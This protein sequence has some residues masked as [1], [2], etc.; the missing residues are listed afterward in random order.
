[1]QVIFDEHVGNPPVVY[2]LVG[3]KEH[4]ITGLRIRCLLLP[5]AYEIS[6]QGIGPFAARRRDPVT[7]CGSN[8]VRMT[9]S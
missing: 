2:L 3:M 1:M 4:P 7:H 8:R 9:R 5:Q 6:K